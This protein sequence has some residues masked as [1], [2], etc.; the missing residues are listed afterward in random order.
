M[1]DALADTKAMLDARRALALTNGARGGPGGGSNG[2]APYEELLELN[3]KRGCPGDSI[4]DTPELVESRW[5]TGHQC[6]WAKGEP[7]MLVGPDGVGKTSVAQQ[8]TLSMARRPS[9]FAAGVRRQTGGPGAL[10][11]L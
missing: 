9:T 2:A 1:T 7:T 11:R 4:L 3:A 10:P 6:A 8:A 5:G